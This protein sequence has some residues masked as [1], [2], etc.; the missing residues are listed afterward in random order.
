MFKKILLKL[1]CAIVL[2][3]VVFSWAG[4]VYGDEQAPE[5]KAPSA[6]LVESQRG[7]VLY[8]KDPKARLHISS[9]NKIMTALLAIEKMEKQLDA[10]VTV[11]KKAVSVEGSILNLEVGGKYT[12]ED[13]VYT[14]V[15]TS[16]NDT[17]NA[18]AE[19]IGGDE[20]SFVELMNAK[21]KKLN[22]LDTKFTNPT[23]LYD[24]A[25]Y[26]TAYDVALLIR[27]AIKIPAFDRI[28]SS[29]A[30]PWTDQNGTQVL[31]NSNELFFGGYDGVDGGKTGYNERSKHT[32]I[33]TAT[34]NNQ[35]LICVVLDSPLENL[36]GDSVKLL[37]YGFNNYK[38][39]ILVSK[40]QPLK[41]VQ[42]GDEYV[43]L[44]SISD[45]YYTFPIGENYIKNI[46]FNISDNL[47]PP[48]T[49]KEVLGTSKYTLKDGTV[50]EISLYPNTNIYSSVSMLSSLLQ[51]MMNYRE[52]TILL[53]I[54]ASVE[55]I[56]I[57]YNIAKLIKKAFVKLTYKFKS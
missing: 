4:L 37:D 33:T 24:E 45:Y 40:D 35:R 11:S 44:I 31:V 12:V 52:I 7:Q 26:T 48:I 13:L 28:F 21:A 41:R 14:V 23:G 42:I 18:L 27:H 6:I 57:L 36:Y 38:T 20:K 34:R 17:A 10:K 43:D 49:K 2:L 54:L 53:L 51:K 55:L 39:G 25:Q 22:M 32:A 46:E 30:K 47:K 5:I 16:A 19:F 50:I 29:N 15:L 9:A 56:L 3:F 8:E 1:Q